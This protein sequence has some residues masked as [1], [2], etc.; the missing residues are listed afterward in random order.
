MEEYQE[1]FIDEDRM[2]LEEQFRQRRRE[3]DERRRRKR[4]QQYCSRLDYKSEHPIWDNIL[5]PL[6]EGFTNS[7]AD[8]IIRQNSETM[9]DPLV[10]IS[11]HSKTILPTEATP[12]I[13]TQDVPVPVKIPRHYSAEFKVHLHIRNLPKGSASPE[14]QATAQENGVTL[15]EG[16][17]WVRDFFKGTG[18]KDQQ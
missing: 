13:E 3:R 7:F 9:L 4:N 15:K 8:S 16:Q 17:T 14:K 11:R 1:P 2:R 12:C 6:M 5:L 18:S 10:V